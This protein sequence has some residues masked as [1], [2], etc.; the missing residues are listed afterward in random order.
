LLLACSG[1]SCSSTEISVSS[2]NP[3]SAASH[4]GL[5]S[6]T[7]SFFSGSGAA[8]AS[9]L[10]RGPAASE[11]GARRPAPPILLLTKTSSAEDLA[12]PGEAD[13][14]GIPGKLGSL[15]ENGS[16]FIYSGP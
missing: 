2:L 10:S 11:G 5:R 4:L 12:L 15:L 8:S 7:F 6:T 1:G 14:P 3:T 13:A 16:R 9:G